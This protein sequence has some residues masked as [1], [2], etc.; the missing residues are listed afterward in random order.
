MSLSEKIAKRIS[1]ELNLDHEKYEVINYGLFA[2]LQITYSLLLVAVFGLIFGLIFQALVVS[3]VSSILRQYSGG[4]HASKPSICLFIGTVV[5]V[6]IAC[7]ASFISK[8][9]NEITVIIIGLIIVVISYYIIYKRAP[10]DSKAK[11][12]K[13]I[14]KRKLM[15]RN[16]LIILSIYLLIVI[17]LLIS[18]YYTRNIIYVEYSIC[19]Y[20]AF[21]WQVFSL[22]IIGH[23]VLTKV[24]LFI[25]KT[26]FK[27]GG[28]LNEKI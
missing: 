8:N 3:F 25:G 23:K 24:D 28:N 1:D 4:V 18:Y 12:I 9:V 16:S 6:S 7:I 14:V 27:E 20:L 10:V 17:I 21:G 19:I 11:P 2:F 26:I 15:R 5:T 22:T 13:S